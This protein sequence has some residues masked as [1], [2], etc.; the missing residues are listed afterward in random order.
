MSWMT[1]G[2]SSAGS[3]L[4]VW[5]VQAERASLVL[6]GKQDKARVQSLLAF[7][8]PVLHDVH[9]ANADEPAAVA[10]HPLARKRQENATGR[11]LK[12]GL[13]Q[14][15][16]RWGVKLPADDILAVIVSHPVP[17]NCDAYLVLSVQE[18]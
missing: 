18:R 11:L 16:R 15:T 5:C 9:Y 1:P 8:Q 7:A 12:T 4:P 2:A 6:E 13:D 3:S 10:T 17:T 14:S